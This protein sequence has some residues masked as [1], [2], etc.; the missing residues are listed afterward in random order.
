[1]EL[2]LV[3]LAG[4]V[5]VV[6]AYTDVRSLTIPNYLIGILVVLA[7]IHALVLGR[8]DALGWIGAVAVLLVGLLLW[9]LG[10]MGA[11]DV[12]LAS[13]ALLWLPGMAIDFLIL[14]AILGGL[15][16]LGYLIA[17]LLKK[18]KFDKIPY[19]LPLALAT[20]AILTWNVIQG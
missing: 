19:G 9:R 14:T 3:I 6:A 12:K 11:G 2:I 16:S 18:K 1:M 13:A 17:G 20:I 8:L 15:L 5:L 7:L 4:L 10:L